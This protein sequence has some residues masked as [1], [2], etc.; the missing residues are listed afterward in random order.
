MLTSLFLCSSL[1]F[2]GMYLS[3][4][5]LSRCCSALS[6]LEI[7]FWVPEYSCLNVVPIY[8]RRGFGY[9]FFN[10]MSIWHFPLSLFLSVVC[11]TYPSLSLWPFASFILLPL[12]PFSST[13]TQWCC[14]VCQ[15]IKQVYY[16]IMNFVYM[17]M[18]WWKQ[19]KEFCS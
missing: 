8:H 10:T 5:C 1:H 7:L 17:L 2:R 15:K 3:F 19:L 6:C 14:A 13:S 12:F 18:K 16:C 9:M 11:C 4:S